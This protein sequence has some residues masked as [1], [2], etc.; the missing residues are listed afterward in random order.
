MVPSQSGSMWCLPA[1][2]RRSNQKSKSSF[3]YQLESLVMEL[4]QLEYFVAVAQEAN[5]TRAAARL[6]VA[7]PGVSAQIKGLEREVGQPLFDRSGR[8]VRLTQ[9]GAAML[10]HAQAALAAVADA[11]AAVDAIGGLLRGHV[12]VGMVTACASVD[13]A[14]LLASFHAEHPGVEIHL[15]EANSDVLL[16]S[17]QDG[18]LDLAWVAVAGPT[19][20][21]IG[22]VVVADETLVA[23]VS[24]QDEWADRERVTLTH[25]VRRPLISLPPGT[26]MRTALDQACRRHGLAADV[27]LEATSP[28]LLGQLARQGLGVAILATSMAEADPGLHAVAI[29]NP[30]LRGRI[31]LAWRADGRTSPA[32]RALI[33]HAQAHLARAAGRRSAA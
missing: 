33:A 4:R 22:S 18:S 19:A 12:A 26:G 31:E 23:A 32:G 27:A 1:V 29:T 16:S 13:L 24:L 6:H 11:R 5:F 8:T 25:L 7:Q 30:A 14:D 9:A 21:G 15:S 20:P 2:C 10:P 17:L 28:P 3:C